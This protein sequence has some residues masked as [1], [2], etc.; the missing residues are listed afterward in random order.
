M[1]IETMIAY[2]QNNMAPDIV[3]GWQSQANFEVQLQVKL[4]SIA[5]THL[6]TKIGMVNLPNGQQAAV[7]VQGK[8]SGIGLPTVG[9]PRGAWAKM[10]EISFPTI[11][12][13]ADMYV[14]NKRFIV[15]P[16]NPNGLAYKDTAYWIELKVE[17]PH[18]HRFGGKSLKKAYED[19]FDKLFDQMIRDGGSAASK[20]GLNRKRYWVLMIALS[21]AERGKMLSYA[22]HTHEWAHARETICLGYE[23]V[24]A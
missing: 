13:I 16:N 14:N 11:Q 4:D 8:G 9:V 19:D 6:S 1:K 15:D 17:S 12:E 22:A 5:R 21:P 7:Q 10:R 20:V 3:E 23:Q 2:I 24:D 18:T